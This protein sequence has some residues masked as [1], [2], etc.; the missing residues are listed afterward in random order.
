[1]W[2]KSLAK[3]KGDAGGHSHWVLSAEA[4][5]PGMPVD[6]EVEVGQELPAR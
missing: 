6:V 5:F 3:I 4:A 1:M 2:I